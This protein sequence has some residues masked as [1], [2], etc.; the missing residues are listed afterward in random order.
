VVRTH[1][2][3]GVHR[4]YAPGRAVSVTVRTRHAGAVGRY[5]VTR[6][7]VVKG[8]RGGKVRVTTVRRGRRH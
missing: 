2:V 1:R 8:P 5:R 7:T 3:I 6:T 4:F